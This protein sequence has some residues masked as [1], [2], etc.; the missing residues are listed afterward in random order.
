MLFA[1]RLLPYNFFFFSEIPSNSFYVGMGGVGEGMHRNREN[2]EAFAYTHSYYVA[3]L[4]F[5]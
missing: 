2:I 5:I 3:P 1:K 4:V